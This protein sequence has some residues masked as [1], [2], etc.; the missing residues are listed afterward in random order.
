MINF[1]NKIYSQYHFDINSSIE[2]FNTNYYNFIFYLN[3]YM[4]V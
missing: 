2:L 1:K 4:K 3:L